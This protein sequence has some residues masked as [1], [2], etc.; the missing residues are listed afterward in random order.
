MSKWMQ[1]LADR[2]DLQAKLDEAVKNE[3]YEKAAVYR[4]FLKA[5]ERGSVSDGFQAGDDNE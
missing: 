2:A 5:L 1:R 3:N 4:D